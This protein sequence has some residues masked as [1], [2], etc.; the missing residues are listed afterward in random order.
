MI[1]SFRLS[2]S[3]LFWPQSLLNASLLCIHCLP[4]PFYLPN[5]Y[6]YSCQLSFVSTNCFISFSYRNSFTLSLVFLFTRCLLSPPP[7]VTSATLSSLIHFISHALTPHSHSHSPPPALIPFPFLWTAS[8]SLYLFS[9]NRSRWQ[10]HGEHSYRHHQCGEHQLWL[11]LPL[12]QGV[13]P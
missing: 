2:I 5:S 9:T 11:R 1:K 8:S 3:L 12:R 13:V 6:F 4:T 10:T 7:C